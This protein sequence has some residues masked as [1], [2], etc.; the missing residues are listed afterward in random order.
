MAV[1]RDSEVS[2]KP[3]TSHLQPAA[4]RGPCGEREARLL[5]TKFGEEG[6]TG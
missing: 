2:T 5:M 1:A 4:F 6:T 3:N